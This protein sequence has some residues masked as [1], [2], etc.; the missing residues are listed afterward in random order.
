MSVFKEI[1]PTAGLPLHCK[2]FLRLFSKKSYCR[3][4]EGDFENYLGTPYARV[5]Y[6][7]TAALYLVLE[8]LKE[9]SPK[10]TVI[11]PSFVCPLVPLA[12][13]RTGF[14][15]EVCDINP[16]KFNF[17][18]QQLEELC[19]KKDVLA[20]VAVHLAGIP[21]DFSALK[22]ISGR[23]KIFIIEDCAQ[24]L[25][26]SYKG[27]KTGTL[28]D[29]SFFSLCRGKGLT[30]YE[31]GVIATQK[32]EYSK[33]IDQTIERL[34]KADYFSETLKTLE[35][36]GY[37][38]FYRPQLFWFVYRL[39]QI[40]WEW[41]GQPLRGVSEYYTADFP[42]HKVSGIRKS[43]GHITFGRLE[44]EIDKQREKAISYIQG[45]KNT[46]GMKLV[47]EPSNTKANYPYLVLLFDDAQKCRQAREVFRN[48]GL[49]V[50]QI[51][52]AA[53]TDYDYLK[54]IIENIPSP[55][56][57]SLAQRHITLS[58]STFLKEKDLQSVV[59]KIKNL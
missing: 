57:R 9:I 42:I 6:S 2:D 43:I 15:I 12:I 55:N 11:I 24:S 18:R 35:L 36:L 34:V 54:D 56:A 38:V 22:E 14:K 37:L 19:L 31:G 1:P 10:K 39:V 52:A 17:D 5:T 48:S 13:K 53:I 46:P 50:S 47:T 32:E 16:D 30:I 49:G 33:I 51:Y 45:L 27:K 40:F 20:I 3:S 23:N 7:G 21:L 29:F 58:T 44:E 8:A 41:Q 4:L 28:G 26:A 59:N 25:G